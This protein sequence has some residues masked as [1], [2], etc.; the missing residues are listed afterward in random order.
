[1]KNGALHKLELPC[2]PV[3]K[4]NP[5]AKEEVKEEDEAAKYMAELADSDVEE[6]TPQRLA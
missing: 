4:N 5:G 2:A 3:V 1:M 6:R